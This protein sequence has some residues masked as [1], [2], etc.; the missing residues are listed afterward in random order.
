MR[1][2]VLANVQSR[3]VFRLPS[4]DA[5]IIAAGSTLDPEDFQGLGAYEC[6][7]QLVAGAS[8]QPWCSGRT[9]PPSKP[10]SDPGVVRAAS[11]AAYGTPRAEVDADIQALVAPKRQRATDDLSPRRRDHGG[12]L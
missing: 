7:A 5:R 3:V 8:V 9:L 2:A 12:G 11:R 4:E 6:Y 1:S 10:T